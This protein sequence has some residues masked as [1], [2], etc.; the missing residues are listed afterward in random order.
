MHHNVA[1]GYLAVLILALCL[2]DDVRS[3]VKQFMR[4]N[5]LSVV[6]S[7]VDE[8][9]Q[10]HRKIE[11]ELYPLQ[12]NDGSSGFIARLEGLVSQ[13]QQIELS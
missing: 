3:Q 10:Y 8:F 6:R 12:T 2:D 5:G 13:I 7:T 9:L 4:P 11:Q 1:V